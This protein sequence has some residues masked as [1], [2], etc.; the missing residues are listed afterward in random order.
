MTSKK[1]LT[2]QITRF[3]PHIVEI[4][5]IAASAQYCRIIVEKTFGDIGPPHV[6]VF[7]NIFIVPEALKIIYMLICLIRFI[8]ILT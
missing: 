8:F 4:F 2:N 7:R 1:L 3:C 5:D 6:V